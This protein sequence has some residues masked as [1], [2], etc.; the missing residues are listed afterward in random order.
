MANLWSSDSDLSDTE[1]SRAIKTSPQDDPLQSGPPKISKKSQLLQDLLDDG[2]SGFKRSSSITS[3]SSPRHA[4]SDDINYYELYCKERDERM[5]LEAQVVKLNYRISELEEL[6]DIKTAKPQATQSVPDA[7]RDKRQIERQKRHMANAKRPLRRTS[8]VKN[9]KRDHSVSGSKSPNSEVAESQ[10]STIPQFEPV[11]QPQ[12]NLWDSD[13]SGW[14]SD[15]NN[16][17]V[18]APVNPAPPSQTSAAVAPQHHK[19][20]NH[21]TDSTILEQHV[22]DAVLLWAKGKDILSMIKSLYVIY[23]GP[24]PNLDYT[25]EY[26]SPAAPSEIRRMYL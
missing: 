7:E 13:S 5:I 17:D 6:L 3:T 22:N 4:V 12:V 9:D 20:H 2:G 11:P 25:V 18:S 19:H 8:T 14:S 23:E 26:T 16:K 10:P 21:V 1:T 15:E 24:L